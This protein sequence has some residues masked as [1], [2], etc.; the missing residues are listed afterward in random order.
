MGC[1]GHGNAAG[2]ELR[3]P[4]AGLR[5]CAPAQFLGRQ[6]EDE[7]HLHQRKVG[8]RIQHGTDRVRGNEERLLLPEAAGLLA[9][10]RDR[11][12]PAYGSLVTHAPILRRHCATPTGADMVSAG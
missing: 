8:P 10:R 12:Q 11:P 1:A 3:Q 7:R 2:D 9:A 5:L 6:G 4:N